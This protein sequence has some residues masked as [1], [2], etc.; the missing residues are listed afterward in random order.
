[1]RLI[2]FCAE[3][4][5]SCR[6]FKEH[7]NSINADGLSKVW[8]DIE[9]EASLINEINI[10]NLPTILAVSDDGHT[11]FFGEIPPNKTFLEKILQ[12]I[13]LGKLAPSTIPKPLA[14][15]VA[16]IAKGCE[17]NKGSA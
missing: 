14:D 15:L 11:Y 6:E 2:L 9:D 16:T 12:D 13:S 7:F 17:A 10:D 5:G 4:C 1:M 3:W 8:L